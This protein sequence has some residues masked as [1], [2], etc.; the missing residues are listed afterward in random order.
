MILVFLSYLISIIFWLWM[1]MK[2]DK[3]DRE[4]LKSVLLVL[5]VGGLISVLPA[6]LFNTMFSMLINYQLPGSGGDR[7]I[8]NSVL[9]FAFVGFNEE[10]FKAFATV[11][12]IRRMKAFNEPAD[13]L[14]YAMTVAFGFSLFENVEYSLKYGFATFYIRQFNAVP[15]HVGLAAIWGI[16]I[17][18]ARFVHQ[19]KYFQTIAAYVFIA[20]FIHAVYNIS[21]TL[22]IEPIFS[23][24]IL[25]VL[26]YYLIRFAI[27]TIKRYAED[28]PFSN[29]LYCHNCNTENSPNAKYCKKCLNEFD[30]EFY[31]LCPSC[32]AKVS[33]NSPNCPQC[34]TV[35]MQ[36]IPNS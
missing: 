31:T 34:G 24:I 30:L 26:A 19:G 27:K 8:E 1:I 35:L 14:V 2:F 12:L 20:A 3:F 9:F 5:V 25:S 4:P 21:T 15:L 22:P 18:K 11:F 28:G 10:F 16:G 23:L 13:A 32:N 29:R 7:S 33:V 6:G 17:A 36:K